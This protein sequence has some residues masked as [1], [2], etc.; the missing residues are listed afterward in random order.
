MSLLKHLPNF[1]IVGSMKSG[2]TSLHHWLMNSPFIA[3]SKAETHFFNREERFER[4]PDEYLRALPVAKND[5]LVGDDT[6]T[7]SYL[8]YIPERIVSMVPNVKI[9]WILRDPLDRAVSQYWHAVRGGSEFRGIN[10]AFADE[11]SG[12]TLNIW[13][14]YIERSI[15][16]RQ[17]NRYLKFF[18][19]SNLCF[20]NFNKFAQGEPD[21]KKKV[22]DF[23]G[24]PEIKEEVPRSNETKFW[25]R[26][27]VV[28]LLSWFPVPS[29]IKKKARYFFS[30]SRKQI[31]SLNPDLRSIAY[32]RLKEENSNI[33]Q[34][35]GFNVWKPSR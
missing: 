16:E 35:V 22:S 23:L 33:E 21:E 13:H 28:S 5:Q 29:R 26:E 19:V 1:I 30:Y 17:I 27:E 18:D 20:V 15:Y 14:K 25:P 7:Y 34:L 9:L 2:T 8:D 24:I 12:M 6:P 4:G 10:Q 32:E 31:P 11:L 3:M